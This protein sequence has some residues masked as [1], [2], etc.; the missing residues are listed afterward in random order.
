MSPEL[1]G[2]LAGLGFAA[3][4]IL[5]V[6][7]LNRPE[8]APKPTLRK[9]ERGGLATRMGFTGP[10]APRRLRNLGI[11]AVAGIVLSILTRSV[12]W[13]PIF[14]AGSMLLPE[15]LRGGKSAS[16]AARSEA[17][18]TWTRSLSGVLITGVGLEEAVRS[19]LASTPPAI[20][21]EMGRLVARLEAGQP[22][23]PAVRLWADEMN[24][25]TS[26]LVAGA[27]IMGSRTRKGGLSRALAELADAVADQTRVIQQIEAERAGPRA[28][29]Q[30]V[31]VITI[32]LL[33][34]VVLN[35]AFGE[36]YRTA[37][38]Q[39]VLAIVATAYLGVLWWMKKIADGKS[40]PRFLVTD[41]LAVPGKRAS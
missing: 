12:I 15:L 32:G 17:L 26:D 33:G 37:L 14:V 41:P 40:R 1:I 23:E 19:S 2:L 31:T 4:V 30:W 16:L 38:G 21:P 10:D 39:L 3:G 29:V 20:K 25:A 7:G 36:A 27:L 13:V 18:E 11:G 34:F 35:P 6:L 8:T 28:T 9:K 24:D 5:F 22:I